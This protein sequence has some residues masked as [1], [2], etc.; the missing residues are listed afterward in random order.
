MTLD[1]DGEPRATTE[2]P[3]TTRVASVGPGFFETFGISAAQGRLLE[4]TDGST[5]REVVVVNQRFV[6]RFLGGGDPLG[7]RVMLRADE[8][9]TV[10]ASVVG[11]VPHIRHSDLTANEL[12]AVVYRPLA[13]ST[14]AGFTIAMRASQPAALLAASLRDTVTALDQD[15][16][17]FQIRTMAERL[18]QER[19]PFR[20]FGTLFVL[21]AV[22]GLVLSTIGMYAM[23]AYAV[24]QRR[25]EI[26][27]RMALGAQQSQ[28]S[29]LVLRRGLVQL[30]IGTPLGLLFAYLVMRGMES[31]LIG[32]RPGDPLTFVTIFLI[33]GTVTFA[34]CLIPAV[35]AAR[36]NPV[37]ALRN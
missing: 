22:F 37:G 14:T 17:I 35:R 25:A 31:L 5:G 26:G 33:V 9:D 11:V 15:L 3:G 12:D 20:V 29:W 1:I 4:R 21:F 30:A 36:M 24:G 10:W 16:P 18:A 28:V 13:M 27:L 32:L 6:D 7:R 8:T 2:A 19:W 23:T 34:A